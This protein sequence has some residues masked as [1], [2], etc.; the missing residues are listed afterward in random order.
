MR[1]RET[2]PDDPLRPDD[3][4]EVALKRKDPFRIDHRFELA[5]GDVMLSSFA[6]EV[7]KPGTPEYETNKHLA[8][9][10]AYV[11]P[12]ER[13]KHLAS[14]WLPLMLDL[15]VGHGSTVV[16][17][18][19]EQDSG[20]AFM[21]WLG[22]EAR[23]T[24]RESRLR[25]AGVDWHALE[26]WVADGARRSPDTTLETYDGPMPESMWSDF[27]PQLSLML[28]TI[29]FEELDH[30]DIVVTP[31]HIRE[32]DAKL[33]ESG[34]TMHTM[35]T[36]EADGLISGITDTTWGSFRP[37][38]IHQGFTGVRPEA[39]GRGIGKWLKAAMLLHMRELYPD[40]EWITTD[41]AGSN[42]PMLAI[43]EKLGFRSYRVGTAYQMSRERLAARVA[44]LRKTR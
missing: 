31:D 25:L 43:N 7:V 5:S 37:A 39:R 33:I 19:T 21:G 36:R 41:N 28:N 9:A 14:A 32:Y 1:Q 18:W 16:E 4:E 13:R 26:E 20:H 22:A 30:G 6:M 23:L 10:D 35:L 24:S 38:I 2:R 27:A 40:A 3:I 8:W 29:P 17:M 12:D 15:M 11:R 34:Q 42:A 44:E